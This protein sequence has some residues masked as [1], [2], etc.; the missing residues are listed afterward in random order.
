[1]DKDTKIEMIVFSLGFLALIL[2]GFVGWQIGYDS[3]EKKH[4]AISEKW[5]QENKALTDKLDSLDFQ[6]KFLEMDLASC[7]DGNKVEYFGT[8]DWGVRVEY[9]YSEFEG[10]EIY[11]KNLGPMRKLGG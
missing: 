11:L 5:M 8:A 2:V 10:V 7:E 6:N 4:S 1:M 9:P 3:A